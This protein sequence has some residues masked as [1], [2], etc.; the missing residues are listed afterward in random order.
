MSSDW[1]FSNAAET[2]RIVAE[3]THSLFTATVYASEADCVLLQ[4]AFRHQFLFYSALLPLLGDQCY[5]VFTIHNYNGFII[6]YSNTFPLRKLV[7]EQM[8]DES[9]L[10]PHSLI[11]KNKDGKII[12]VKLGAIFSRK[13]PPKEID[14][15]WLANLPFGKPKVN[16]NDFE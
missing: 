5:S 8:V 3:D 10:E 7:L 15:R 14:V 6:C 9:L 2:H 4:T 1:K 11:A 12:G 16:G 13:N